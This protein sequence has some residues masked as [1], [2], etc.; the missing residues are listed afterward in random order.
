MLCSRGGYGGAIDSVPR[1]AVFRDNPKL[2]IG[3]SDI[4]VLH[5]WLLRQVGLVGLYAP[6]PITLTRHI[7]DYALEVFWRAG[8]A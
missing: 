1:S 7:P 5:L 2:L 4:T 3:Y 6:M 8:S